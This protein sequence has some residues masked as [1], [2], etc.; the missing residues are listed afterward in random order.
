MQIYAI[1]RELQNSAHFT[2]QKSPPSSKRQN[3]GRKMPVSK[4]FY[5]FAVQELYKRNECTENI[6]PAG[7]RNISR[8]DDGYH[9]VQPFS[10]GVARSCTEL[11]QSGFSEVGFFYER[12]SR[13]VDYFSAARC[14]GGRS[15]SVCSRSA[16]QAKPL[17][18]GLPA[19]RR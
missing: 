11:T 5:I 13:R 18:P 1:I 14:C 15:N 16:A 19:P 17:R 9:D 4:I 10:P 7:P 2:S 6:R 8:Y 12:I 3:S